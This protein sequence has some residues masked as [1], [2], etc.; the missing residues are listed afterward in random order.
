MKKLFE[1]EITSPCISPYNSQM[2]KTELFLWKGKIVAS[3]SRV[4]NRIASYIT[5]IQQEMIKTWQFDQIMFEYFGLRKGHLLEVYI[6]LLKGCTSCALQGSF[7]L[8]IVPNHSIGQIPLGANWFYQYLFQSV[9]G[10]PSC[11]FIH[12]SNMIKMYQRAGQLG[13]IPPNGLTYGLARGQNWPQLTKKK[14]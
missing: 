12:I 10:F 5:K 13:P 8:G 1:W 7:H 9:T 4:A 11:R 2:T 14:S 3:S 6:F